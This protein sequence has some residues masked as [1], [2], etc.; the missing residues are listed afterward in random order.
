MGSA[1]GATALATGPAVFL[2]YASE[3]AAAAHEG[4]QR[5]ARGYFRLEWKLAI[6]RSPAQLKVS[7]PRPGTVTTTETSV[8][9]PMASTE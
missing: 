4:L 7:V 1:P 5:A 3:D 6:E 2:S 9:L 8:M